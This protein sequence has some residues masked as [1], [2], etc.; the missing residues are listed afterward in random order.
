MTEHF[1]TGEPYIPN[2]SPS[3]KHEDTVRLDAIESGEVEVESM[4][5]TH[6]YQ[7]VHGPN[8]TFAANAAEAHPRTFREAIDAA[9]LPMKSD[10]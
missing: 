7:I 10:A 4:G 9:R 5:T 8:G 1:D 2:G 3:T 6:K